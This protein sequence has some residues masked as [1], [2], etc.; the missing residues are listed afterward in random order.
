MSP[1]SLPHRKWPEVLRYLS[2]LRI[3]SSSHYSDKWAVIQTCD[4]RVS[5]APGD[6][7]TNRTEET[8]RKVSRGESRDLGLKQEHETLR[9]LNF[10]A[11]VLAI[12]LLALGECLA[13]D[14]TVIVNGPDRVCSTAIAPASLTLPAAAAAIQAALNIPAVDRSTYYLIHDVTYNSDGSVSEQHWYV[15]LYEWSSNHTILQRVQDTR[16]AHHFEEAR[17]YGS[18]RLAIVYFHRNVTAVDQATAIS[19]VQALRNSRKDT[20]LPGSELQ[21]EDIEALIV[22]KVI[23]G[24]QTANG[25]EAAARYQ[26][27]NTNGGSALSGFKPRALPNGY[28]VDAPFANLSSLTYTIDITKEV[29]APVQ[30]LQGIVGL[31]TAH[32]G[33]Q[34]LPIAL[35][36]TTFCGGQSFEVTPLPSQMVVTAATGKDKKE[37]GKN[38]YDNEQRYWYDFSLALPL[39]SFNDLTV[40]SSNLTLTAKKVE[41]QSLF[42]MVN[43]SPF[44]YDTKKAQFQLLPVFL[45]GMPITGKPLNH[46]LVAAAIGLNRAQF[47]VGIMV[48]HNRQVS[49]ASNSTPGTSNSTVTGSGPVRDSWGA[50]LSYGINFPVSTV[51]NLL[52]KK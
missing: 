8:F 21:N 5:C 19:R 32:G 18:K 50:K 20:K 41:K 7:E 52:K 30:D 51:T 39:K 22:N 24:D 13:S 33:P 4:S 36:L 26:L 14:Q 12:S 3:C 35:D 25:R 44:P 37:I 34:S 31:I 29:P 42:A 11:R 17:V 46:H 23:A 43:L 48:N 10:P 38:T 1:N 28:I 16:L 27:S 49:N 47:F 2:T 40:D 9:K 15:Y 45:Y 6:V